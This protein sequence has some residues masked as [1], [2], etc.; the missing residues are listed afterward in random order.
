MLLSRLTTAVSLAASLCLVAVA[1]PVVTDVRLV[2]APGIVPI[3][4]AWSIARKLHDNRLQNRVTGNNS[5]SLGKSWNGAVLFSQSESASPND[6]TAVS[7]GIEVICTTCYVTGTVS[8]S[9][10]IQNDMSLSQAID[11]FIGEVGDDVKNI[12]ETAYDDIK[13]WIEK[14]AEDEWDSVIEGEKNVS[15]PT[16]NMTFNLET[17]EIP[18]TNLQF[19][20][21][22]M[23]LYVLLDTKVSAQATYTLNIYT[24]ETPVGIASDSG[25]FIGAVFMI[26][27]ILTC[28]AEIE[29][30]SGLHIKLDDGM[31]LDI[32]MFGSNVSSITFNGGGFEFLPVVAVTAKGTIAAVLRLTVEVGVDVDSDLLDASAG[33]EM[34]LA[35][36]VA[37]FVTHLD[38]GDGAAAGDCELHVVQEYTLGLGADVGATLA[39]GSSTWGPDPSTTIPIWY[40]TLA[41]VCAGT[42]TSTATNPNAAPF[43]S[44]TPSS[45]AIFGRAVAA[46]AAMTT[47]T[48]S[49]VETFSGVACRSPSLAGSCPQSLQT[50]TQATRT[51][52]RVTAVAAGSEATWPATTTVGAGAVRSTV[53]FGPGAQRIAATTGPPVSY[54]PPP[55]GATTRG[56]GGPGAGGG[57]KDVAVIAGLS[58]GLGVPVLA[59]VA[60]G[61]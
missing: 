8:W 35:A 16:L 12:T 41:D 57:K 45:A 40:T 34:T 3:D 17:P 39:V 11:N 55:P 49:Q 52:T 6:D 50:T 15:T 20:F 30:S 29:I 32:A 13:T 46:T 21:D 37:K 18:S 27:L 31:A 59:A 54:V 14:Y 9:L 28:D 2:D 22:D 25:A 1:G 24:S 7:V 38:A 58:V 56:A 5:V 33:V 60:V 61:I 10:D 19:Q 53:A 48:L 23:E 51:A 47:T 36:D 43:G 26:D 4:P 44:G 42:A